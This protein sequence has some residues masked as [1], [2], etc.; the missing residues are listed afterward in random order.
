MSYLWEK[1]IDVN[2]IKFFEDFPV[3]SSLP[4]GDL[5]ERISK[6]LQTFTYGVFSGGI[7]TFAEMTVKLKG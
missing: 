7:P 2:I 4:K 5:G 1:V 3:L 6:S